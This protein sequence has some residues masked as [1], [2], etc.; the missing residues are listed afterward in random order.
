MER[1]SC[2]CILP[3]GHFTNCVGWSGVAYE[4]HFFY[5]LL[6]EV[7]WQEV[8]QPD[9]RNRKNE[10]ER[11]RRR[12]ASKEAGGL[13]TAL[14]DVPNQIH[15]IPRSKRARRKE[16]YWFA[17]EMCARVG[18]VVHFFCR[19]LGRRDW[20][21]SGFPA[22]IAF[23]SAICTR[24]GVYT[25]PRCNGNISYILDMVRENIKA[26]VYIWNRQE[27]CL[28]LVFWLTR[29]KRATVMF[30]MMLSFSVDMNML[31]MKS[32]PYIVRKWTS[33][34]KVSKPKSPGCAV[35]GC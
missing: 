1:A 10:T 31:M 35:A 12:I 26:A 8:G 18:R 13:W 21:R 28:R 23:V 2:P 27:N 24:L 22:Y 33:L 9:Q 7:A 32:Q 3:Y 25:C 15:E 30:P 14:H 17:R 16:E 6:D 34:K 19:R 11:Q 29:A 20:K 5:V 4:L